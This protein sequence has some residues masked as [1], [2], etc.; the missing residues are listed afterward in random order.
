MKTI[1]GLPL[2]FSLALC[3]GV[4][5]NAVAGYVLPVIPPQ[6]AQ[7]RHNP[8][9][10]PVPGLWLVTN[11]A[12]DGPG[13]L[14]SAISNAA[15]G[16]TIRF[17][18]KLPASIVLSSSLVIDKNL[19]IL[20]PGPQLL[21]VTRLAGSNAPAFRI[22]RV[23]DGA[24]TLAGLSLVNGRARSESGLGDNLGGG[25]YNAGSLTVSNCVLSRNVA[26]SEAGG[27]GFGAGIFTTGPLTIL[28]S[29]IS[30]NEASFAGGGLC[31]FH[32]DAV[33]LEGC[34]ISG[35]FAAIQGGGVNYQGR[36][37][38]LKNCTVSGNQTAADG[39]ASALLHIVFENEASDLDLT[40]C[41]FARNTGSPVGAI[42]VAALQ[43]NLGINTRITGS[44][45]AD[46]EGGN[47]FL[48]GSPVLQSLGHN[49]DSDGTS[50]W[51]NGIS[52]DLVGTVASPL[53]ALLSPLQ[54]NGGP[55]QTHALL[56]GSPALDAGGC[57]AVDSTPITIDQRGLPRP[58]GAACDIGAFENQPPQV[59]CPSAHK[60]EACTDQLC[61]V[62]FDSDGD[63]L[64][65]IWLVDGAAVQTNYLSATHPPDS[66]SVQLQTSLSPSSHTIGLRVSDGKAEVIECSTTVD[67]NDTKPPKISSLKADP[68]VLSP[69]NNQLIPVTV[70]VKAVDACGPVTSKI[71]SVSSS[72][73]PGHDPDWII[74]GDLTLLL[75]AE[76]S[77]PNSGRVYTIN[78][79]CRDA[80]GNA[81]SGSVKVTVPGRN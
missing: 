16:N 7:A 68:A 22:L 31:T 4:A 3:G 46:N 73:P 69:V 55:T 13:S 41:T 33:R 57:T 42:V 48:D 38:T 29:T 10:P 63:P 26:L 5:I 65:L 52:G 78:I 43:N 60:V 81:S 40:A 53:A 27:N 70:S 25:I 66:Q 17:A 21:T 37:G 36:T 45:F 71:V 8:P 79:R 24:V 75:R 67:A 19:A 1:H 50:G 77:K 54:D 11:R 18:L 51:L 9:P 2:C 30:G 28:N 59:S 14:R 20:G 72:D 64:S 56:Y 44:L 6:T 76:R 49:L 35:N 47:F 39:A 61:A 58:Q 62:V 74:T 32:S 80:S 15:P 23:D 12:D 34:T